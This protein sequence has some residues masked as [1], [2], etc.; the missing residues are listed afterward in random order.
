FKEWK[1]EEIKAQLVR[2][3]QA[4]NSWRETSFDERSQFLKKVAQ[5]LRGN[6]KHYS[7]LITT[8]MGKPILQAEAE[9]E[10][11]A[12][13]CEFY[14]ENGKKF[15]E[16][17]YVETDADV[18]YIRF[19][20]L[21]VILAIMPWNFPFWQVFRCAAPALMAGNTVLL[22]HSSNVPQCAVTIEEVFNEAGFPEDVFCSVLVG[23][24]SVNTL[25][26][27]G[28]VAAVSLTGSSFAG[29]STAS[30]AGRHLKKVVLELGGSDPFIVLKDV[31]L[32]QAVDAAVKAR[33]INN[34]QSCIAA[35]RFIV[36]EDVF[37]GFKKSFLKK[38]NELVVGDPMDRLTDVGPLAR[39]DIL[40]QL[41]KQVKE[42]VKKGAQVLTGGKRLDDNPGFYYLPTLLC[43]VKKG[44]PCYDEETF[45]PVASL[46]KVKN[47]KEALTVAND[48]MYGLGA[49]IWTKDFKKGESLTRYLEAGNVFVNEIVKSDP[50]LPFGGM[51]QS[52]FGRE[53]SHYGIKE[54]VNIQTVYIK[55]P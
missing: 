10:K 55:K 46:I 38:I 37:E 4:F 27:D 39:K 31:D 9:V 12:W 32:D 5:V 22:K 11:C 15:L 26:E 3:S 48:T 45:G 19:S 47:E 40:D 52:G 34:G 54:F 42:S 1:Q 6:K 28:R 7:S 25:V 49:S 14:A 17:E 35:K 20:P 36:V 18:S 23:S 41:D 43:G 2:S 16:N 21:G 8:E 50:R 24:K 44:M 30:V 33:M 53:L 13:V 29:S 51:K